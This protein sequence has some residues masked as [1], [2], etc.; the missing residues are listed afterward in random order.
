MFTLC[1]ANSSDPCNKPYAAVLLPENEEIEAVLRNCLKVMEMA[2]GR[3]RI[4]V[5]SDLGVHAVS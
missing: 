2:S 5:E 4:C 3:A 1:Q